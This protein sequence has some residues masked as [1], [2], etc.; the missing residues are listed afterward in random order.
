M[1]PHTIDLAHDLSAPHFEG[2]YGPLLWVDASASRLW[3]E[4]SAGQGT[5]EPSSATSVLLVWVGTPVVVVSLGVR[6][7]ARAAVAHTVRAVLRRPEVPIVF[8]LGWLPQKGGML[9][10]TDAPSTAAKRE[11]AR[12]EAYALVQARWLEGDR[13]IVELGSESFAFTVSSAL[14]ASGRLHTVVQ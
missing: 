13:V 9:I 11:L 10:A 8:E 7:E 5:P 12:A 3:Q 14:D 2:I 6:D 1:E 4:G